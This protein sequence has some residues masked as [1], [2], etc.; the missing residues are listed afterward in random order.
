MSYTLQG[1]QLNG[2]SQ[3]VSYGDDAAA[4]TNYPIV[5]I[6]HLASGRVTYCRTFDHSSMGVATGTVIHS[7]NFDVPASIPTGLSELCAVANGISSACVTL[8]VARRFVINPHVYETWNWLMGSLA[9]GPLWVWGPHGPVPVD[10]LGEK[11]AKRAK[12]ARS[13]MLRGMQELAH[14]GSEIAA[15]RQSHAELVA[16]A[17]DPELAGILAQAVRHKIAS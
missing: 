15:E 13:L 4:A 11:Y 2:L 3:A 1:R 12:E 8:R 9:D 10:P 14:L 7:T 5:R 6:R 17:E 16:P